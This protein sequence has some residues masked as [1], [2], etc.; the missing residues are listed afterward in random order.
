MAG[1]GVTVL[2]GERMGRPYLR[3]WADRTY[4]HY[5][6]E[7]LAG[8]AAELGGGPVGLATITDIDQAASR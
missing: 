4:G 8:I 7:T 2:P 6:W 1:V 3:L 5:F